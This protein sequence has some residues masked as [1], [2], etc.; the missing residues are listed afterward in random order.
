[1]PV[2]ATPMVAAKVEDVLNE[3]KLAAALAPDD[4]GNG[5]TP[6]ARRTAAQP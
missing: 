4:D 6:L 5:A 3:Q 1:M 2:A